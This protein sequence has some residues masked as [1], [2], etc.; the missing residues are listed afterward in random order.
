MAKIS[1]IQVNKRADD[2]F[3]KLTRIEDG[4]HGPSEYEVRADA[5]SSKI[6][7]LKALRLARDA[8]LVAAPPPAPAPAPVKK[9]GKTKKRPAPSSAVSLAHW[10]KG[11]QAK[12]QQAG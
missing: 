5:L 10:R 12:N 3:K 4:N 1:S 11:R 6:A 7:R 9:A 8:A 2:Q